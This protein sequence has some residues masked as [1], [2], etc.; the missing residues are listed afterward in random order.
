MKKREKRQ[1]ISL[2]LKV[3][4]L[5]GFLF[6]IFLIYNVYNFNTITEINAEEIK[7]KLISSTIIAT[8]FISAGCL[9]FIIFLQKTIFNPVNQLN[10]TIKQVSNGNLSKRLV[11]NSN[12]EIGL[13]VKNFNLMSDNLSFLISDSAL[14]S[15]SVSSYSKQLLESTIE[16]L[17]ATQY[18]SER[19]RSN[20]QTSQDQANSFFTT[21]ENLNLIS[22]QINEMNEKSKELNNI[23][24]QTTETAKNGE[25]SLQL[26]I[27]QFDSINSS[28]KSSAYTINILNQKSQQVGQIV[29]M[30]DDISKQTNLLALNASIEAAR[31]GEH[32]KGFHVVASEVKK[33]AE[34][35]GESVNKILNIIKEV[36][37]EADKAIILTEKG[38]KEVEQ[39]V[40]YINQ[41][42]EGFKKISE[43]T[44]FSSDEIIKFQTGSSDINDQIKVLLERVE[45]DKKLTQIL[46][47]D[48][49]NIASATEEQNASM[50]EISSSSQHLSDLAEKLN[51][52]NSK[53]ELNTTKKEH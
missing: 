14:L 11:S 51:E 7:F 45:K 26:I 43:K 10:E 20:A 42:N 38:I 34:E 22:Q 35:S 12:D 17:E 53:F 40:K 41:T 2:K 29:D 36:Q 37:G 49:E 24:F 32:G 44:L 47:S 30:I 31:A 21:L 25:E 15:K 1:N 46:S 9:I 23:A 28:V 4:S 6:L 52:K 27:N 13:L 48:S 8:L 39:G 16:N 50:Q 33:L 5:F 19:A 3:F 18:I